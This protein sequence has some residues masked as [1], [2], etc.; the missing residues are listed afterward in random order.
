MFENIFLSEEALIKYTESTDTDFW[1]GA[2]NLMNPPNWTWMDGTAFEFSDWDNN[3][4][5]TSGT[6]CGAAIMQGG[7]WIPDD[8]FKQKP[9]VSFISGHPLWLGWHDCGNGQWGWTDGT[10]PHDFYP[11]NCCNHQCAVLGG[12]GI[13]YDRCDVT[14]FWICKKR[15]GV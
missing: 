12:G 5:S 7:K 1:I 9:Y 11:P 10:D 3:K 8:C 4:T 14:H 15:P 2:T 13:Y 6:D